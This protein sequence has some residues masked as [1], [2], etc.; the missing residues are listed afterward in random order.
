MYKYFSFPGFYDITCFCYEV[1]HYYYR[2]KIVYCYVMLCV[3][4]RIYIMLCFI[5]AVKCCCFFV[6]VFV[7]NSFQ[8]TLS[9]NL[10]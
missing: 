4:V 6:T 1:F 8:K 10:K 7:M 9:K 2:L 3:Q 5:Y